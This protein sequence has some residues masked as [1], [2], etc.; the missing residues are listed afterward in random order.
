MSP[1]LRGFILPYCSDP[2]RARASQKR[3]QGTFSGRRVRPYGLLKS[4]CCSNDASVLPWG[5]VQRISQAYMVSMARSYYDF[6]FSFR[7][8]KYDV[9]EKVNI[10]AF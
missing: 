5:S 8:F 10:H 4:Y 2:D 3:L 6:R 9:I 1:V 7:L